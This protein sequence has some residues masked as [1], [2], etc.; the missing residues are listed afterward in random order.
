MRGGGGFQDL[1]YPENTTVAPSLTFRLGERTNLNLFYEYSR[2]YAN[3]TIYDVPLLSDGNLPPAS[4]S[5][6]YFA[7]VDFASHRFGYGLN[8]ELND[9]WQIRNNLAINLSSSERRETYYADILND[10]TLT[11]YRFFGGDY[12]DN[13]YFGLL[14]LVGRFRTGSISH[15]LVAGFDFNR[16]IISNGVFDEGTSL[17]NLDIFDPD[18]NVSLPESP[19]DVPFTFRQTNQSYG[20]YLQD[21]V[22]F[23]NNLKLLIG[24]RYDWISNNSEAFGDGINS[25]VQNDSAF[26][27]RIGLVY[28]PSQNV[29]LYTSYSQSFRPTTGRNSD[30]DAFEPTRGTQYEVGI[31]T[32]FLEGK[33]SANLAAYSLTR[34]N[35]LTPALD[36]DLARQG[37][38]VQTG[39]QR[40]RGIELDI[41]GEILPGWN[42]VASYAYTDAVVTEDN[43]IPEGNRLINVPENQASLWTTYT[44]QEG[45]LKG[46]G[47]GLG[48]FY[49]GERQGDLANTFQLDDYFRTDAAIYYRRGRFNAAVNVRNLLNVDY[50][51]AANFGRLYV[52]R[53]APFTI[54]GSISWEF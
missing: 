5:P 22:T 36:P 7:L 10:R 39:E 14:D 52:Q 26:S 4:L 8:H 6:T 42:V 29:S 18:Y 51:S 19:E 2:Y 12:E 40:S 27:P 34:S 33:L 21:Q 54:T 9:S 41:G 23:S 17:P 50:V 20:F 47:F 46:L 35:V 13:S 16:Y 11:D 32:E 30:N 25:P 43:S 24:G 38:Q 53:G 45:D 49:V 15:Q 44:I 48:V 28:Q 3:P 37:F 1:A 31:R